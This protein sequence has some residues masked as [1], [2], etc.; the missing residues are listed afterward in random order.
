MPVDAELQ[1]IL[2]LVNAVA[3]EPPT[4]D[5]VHELREGFSLLSA[6]FGPGRDDVE[7]D[8]VGVPNGAAPLGLRIYRPT[9]PDGPAR[10]GALVWFHGG[11]WVIGDLDSHD[12]LCRE[13]CVAAGTTVISVDYRLAPEHPYPCAHDDAS[14]ALTWIVEHAV[15][16]GIDPERLAVGGDSAGGHLATVTALRARDGGPRL[17]AQ[18]LVYPVTD[19]DAPSDRYPSRTENATGYLLTTETMEFFT[20]T[21]APD[22]ARRTEPDASPVLVADLAGSPPALVLTAEYDPLRD[23]GARYAQRLGEAGVPTQL[24]LHE[25]ATHMFLQM[26]ST[27]IAQR[28]IAQIVDALRRA[29]VA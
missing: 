18:I 6:A 23:E 1:P 25:G 20:D 19:L 7:V 2:D 11:G 29:G 14:R 24:E 28:A 12:A 5:Q 21:Y 22:V 8:G 17:A 27:A 16:L 13:L 26:T 4:V 9:T 3:A 10:T 15:E